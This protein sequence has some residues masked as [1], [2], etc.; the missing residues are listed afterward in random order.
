MWFVCIVL[1]TLRVSTCGRLTTPAGFLYCPLRVI[2][3]LKT[4]YLQ[5]V[6]GTDGYADLE[7]LLA[8]TELRSR[9]RLRREN[10]G[11]TSKK[12]DQCPSWTGTVGDFALVATMAGRSLPIWMLRHATLVSMQKMRSRLYM[13]GHIYIATTFPCV[14]QRER[15]RRPTLHKLKSN[16]SQH[17]RRLPVLLVRPVQKTGLP[18]HGLQQLMTAIPVRRGETRALHEKYVALQLFSEDDSPA[19]DLPSPQRLRYI[20]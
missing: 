8:L 11:S 7:R 20:L 10:T 5:F 17:I 12:R 6:L 18:W 15:R 2:D 1:L 9:T 13:T 16:R 14:G 4:L 3:G 19:E